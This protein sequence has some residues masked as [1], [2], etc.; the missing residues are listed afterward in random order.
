MT[1]IFTR[2]FLKIALCVL[3]ASVFFA[4]CKKDKITPTF[5]ISPGEG[6][7]NDLITVTGTDIGDLR[8]IVFDNG[9]I[10]AGLNPN[11]NTGSALLFRVPPGANVGDQHIIFTNS[12]GYEFSVPFKVLAIPTIT[13]AMPTEWEAGS[14]IIING[15]YLSTA[16]SASLA[17][18]TDA[19]TIIS[20]TATQMVLQM[21][22]STVPSAKIS[23]TNDAGTSTSSFSLI[24]MDMQRKLFTEDYGSGVQD[25]SWTTSHSNSTDFAIGGT[26]SL[27]QNFAAGGFQ[28]VSFHTDNVE[29]FADYQSL[30]FWA[31]GGADDN[32][33]KISPDGL[34]SGTGATVTVTVPAN[35]WTHLE[36]PI[37]T[38]GSGVT[39]QRF[40]FQIDGPVNGQTIYF[41]N[42]ILIKQ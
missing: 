3:T 26:T 10:A 7:G 21:P 19:I 18:T 1:K 20:Q 4:S 17:G 42:V 28:G 27:K 16:I 32:T 38:L 14:T 31:K 9:N 29:S 25:W 23:I 37:S 11:F 34:I 35:V 2:P 22:A 39:C 36:I 5:S 15:N 8:S 6:A 40:N 13:S 30:S 41:D 24:N 33:I 12:S